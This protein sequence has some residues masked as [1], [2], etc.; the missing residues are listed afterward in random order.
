MGLQRLV[1]VFAGCMV[2][3]QGFST[4]TCTSSPSKATSCLYS[5]QS[6]NNEGTSDDPSRRRTVLS[7]AVGGLLGLATG[8]AWM[9]PE[10]AEAAKDQTVEEGV[11]LYKTPT[12]L[13]YVELEEGT[14][15]SPRYG[16]LC[17]FSYTAYLKVPSAK[18]KEGFD[19]AQNYVT[20]HGNGKM[21]AGLDEGLHTMK[22]GGLRRLVIPPKLGFAFSGLGPLPQYPWNRAKLN[23]LLERMVDERGG[24]LIYDVRLVRVLDDEADQ[25]Y[26]EDAELTPEQLEELQ[27]RL[28]RRGGAAGAA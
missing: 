10:P 1:W 5:Q 12:G 24:N 4:P 2:A 13:K 21:I 9:R 14:G 25:G 17:V 11:T 26:Y 15:I 16:Q 7:S 6:S 23:K 8:G 20:K 28:I 3:I 27:N 19:S 22:V 18:D